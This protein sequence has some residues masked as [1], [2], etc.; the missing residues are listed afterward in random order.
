MTTGEVGNCDHD[1]A[2]CFRLPAAPKELLQNFC[3]T[4]RQNAC[5]DFHPMIQ[6]WMVQHLHYGPNCASFWVVGAINQAAD[7]RMHD[8]SRAHRARLNCNKQ[9]AGGKPMVT[10]GDS[11]LAQSDNFGV[12]GGIFI[13]DVAIPSPAYDAAIMNYHR[14]DRH[15]ACFQRALSGAQGLLH[16]EFVVGSP[17]VRRHRKFA[18][19]RGAMTRLKY[20]GWLICSDEIERAKSRG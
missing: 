1:A 19:E 14:S 18:N 9:V 8:R 2:Q 11:G 5:G 6:F 3:A 4:A 7:A 12:C 10:Q 13:E 17:V 16:P 15:F 20:S